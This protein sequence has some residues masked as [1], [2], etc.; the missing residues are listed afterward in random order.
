MTRQSS[1]VLKCSN[2]SQCKFASKLCRWFA[3]DPLANWLTKHLGFLALQAGNVSGVYLKR[4]KSG[5]E[6]AVLCKCSVVLFIQVILLKLVRIS[7]LNKDY[8]ARP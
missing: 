6:G 5:M 2:E 3:V 8:R 4:F 7:Q 1:A